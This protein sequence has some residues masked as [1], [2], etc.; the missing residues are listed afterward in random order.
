MKPALLPLMLADDD[1]FAALAGMPLRVVATHVYL[2]SAIARQGY[3]P[4]VVGG[5][6]A[7]SD[8]AVGQPFI[9]GEA[10]SDVFSTGHATGSA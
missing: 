10:A 3:V 8:I 6:F 4:P 2:A 1:A 7:A 5:A 9:A